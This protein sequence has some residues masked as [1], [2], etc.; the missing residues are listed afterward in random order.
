MLG[1]RPTIQKRNYPKLE[2]QSDQNWDGVRYSE[3][4]FQAPTVLKFCFSLFNPKDVKGSSLDTAFAHDLFSGSSP[5]ES[6][7]V[8]IQIPDS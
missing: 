8:G 1:F 2:R 4:D 7:T 6:G 3:F 5:Y